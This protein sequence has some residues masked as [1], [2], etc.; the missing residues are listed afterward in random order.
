V[1]WAWDIPHRSQRIRFPVLQ[2]SV[3]EWSKFLLASLTERLA[4]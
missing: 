2:Q 3:Q 4:F 1:S